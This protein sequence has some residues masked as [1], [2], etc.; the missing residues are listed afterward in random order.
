M[1]KDIEVL[2]DKLI[3][4]I[5]YKDEVCVIRE[6]VGK[7]GCDIGNCDKCSKLA[8]KLIRQRLKERVEDGI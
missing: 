2:V 7:W 5:F 3:T 6:K 4:D 8:V 1:Q